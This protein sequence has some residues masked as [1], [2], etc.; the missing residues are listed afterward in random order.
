[1]A[2]RQL[3]E[4]VGL[5]DH[6][7]EFEEGQRLLAL[8][9][10]L[11]AIERQHPVDGEMRADIA[12]EVDVAEL[13]SQSALSTMIASVGPSPKVSNRSNT[14]RIEAMLAWIVSGEQ[15]AA[16]VLARGIADL[17]RAAAHQHDRL[18]P[19]LL[20]PPQQHDLHQAADMERGAVASK[21]I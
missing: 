11:D 6:V 5:E 2:Q 17:G 15:L 18:V 1:M 8:E 21:P 10:Q 9:P 20:Q 19:R 12:Q 4:I 7:V 13:V 16:L 14:V 3:A